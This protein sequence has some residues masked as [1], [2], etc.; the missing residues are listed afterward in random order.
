M[1]G[2]KKVAFGRERPIGFG[3]SLKAEDELEGI[4]PLTPR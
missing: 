1:I 4:A 3:R 2:V